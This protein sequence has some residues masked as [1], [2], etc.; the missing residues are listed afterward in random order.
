MK[1]IIPAL[2]ILLSPVYA[3]ADENESAPV[4]DWSVGLYAVWPNY[5]MIAYGP[6]HFKELELGGRGAALAFGYNA[7]DG[8]ALEFEAGGMDITIMSEHQTSNATN[9]YLIFGATYG[10]T[11]WNFVRPYAGAGIGYAVW[12]NS[13]EFK[14]ANCTVGGKIYTSYADSSSSDD[15]AF[16]YQVKLGTRFII[17][18]RFDVDLNIKFQSL[19]RTGNKGPEFALI[20]NV[21]NIEP[22]M[23]FLYKFGW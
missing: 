7:G 19:G 1:K 20:G 12:S 3:F 8:V 2:F 15:L 22:R 10:K 11:Y 5:S 16:S 17:T 18:S 13:M 14:C 6:N 23:G 21:Q 4:R 9:A